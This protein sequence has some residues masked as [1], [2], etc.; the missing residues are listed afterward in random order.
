[1]SQ[2]NLTYGA[3]VVRDFIIYPPPT[4]NYRSAIL[5]FWDSGFT[6]R[7]I[8]LVMCLVIRVGVDFRN[9]KLRMLNLAVNGKRVWMGVSIKA[10]FGTPPYKNM[11]YFFEMVYS[12]CQNKYMAFFFPIFSK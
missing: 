4:Q 11:P 10:L 7:Q 1:M 5:F 3:F 9:M 6:H 2:K 12:I 8:L